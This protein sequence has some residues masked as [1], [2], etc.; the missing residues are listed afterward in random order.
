[1][2]CLRQID[3][4]RYLGEKRRTTDHY[5]TPGNRVTFGET[6][7]FAIANGITWG[8]LGMFAGVFFWGVNAARENPV[9]L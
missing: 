9:E 7:V 2:Q 8:V 1:M 5:P 4:S 6:F 3:Q